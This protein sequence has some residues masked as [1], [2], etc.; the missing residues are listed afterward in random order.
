MSRA[1][2]PKSGIAAPHTPLRPPD[3]VTGILWSLQYANKTETS[4]VFFGRHTTAGIC[5]T[6]LR[7]DHRSDSGHQSRPCSARSVASAVV[8][9]IAPSSLASVAVNARPGLG[10]CDVA[11]D[12]SPPNSMGSVAL[13]ENV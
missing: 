3:G 8:S 10:R 5:G 11:R 7:S 9:Q 1:T 4:C 13:V 12:G 6:S 2:P